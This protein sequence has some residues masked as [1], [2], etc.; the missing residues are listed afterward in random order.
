MDPLA[1]LFSI[2]GT[3]VAFAGFF[4]M[5]LSSFKQEIRDD[6]KDIKQRQGD[7]DERMFFIITGQKLEDAIK[8]ERMEKQI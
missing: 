5:L 1:L 7:L 3:G 8:K 6:I 4:Y 2:L